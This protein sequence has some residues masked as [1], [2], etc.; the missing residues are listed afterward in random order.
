MP[1]LQATVCR[2]RTADRDA[3]LPWHARDSFH[4]HVSFGFYISRGGGQQ[5]GN[6][7]PRYRPTGGGVRRDVA[8]LL[9]MP[10]LTRHM[11]P[12]RCQWRERHQHSLDTAVGEFSL[13][14]VLAGW[15]V[16]I[17]TQSPH[18]PFMELIFKISK[19][20]SVCSI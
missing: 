13:Y 1:V 16:M 15:V 8:R 9:R 18:T 12:G 4:R 5:R 7:L 11:P 6:S 10:T 14:T 2:R 17:F 3:S 19:A 20:K